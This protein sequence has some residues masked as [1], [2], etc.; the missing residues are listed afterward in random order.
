MC[1]YTSKESVSNFMGYLKGRSAIRIF[2]KYPELKKKWHNEFWT[3][4][5]LCNNSRRY[6]RRSSKEIYI[7]NQE[8]DKEASRII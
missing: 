6:N 4:K 5:I 3:N 2:E 1:K 7:Q 8:E